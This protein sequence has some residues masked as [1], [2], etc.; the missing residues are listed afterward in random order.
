[1]MR[2]ETDEE[3]IAAVLH[4]VVE[5]THWTLDMLKN[6]GFS[7]AVLK[8]IEHLT[9]R[10]GEDYEKFIARVK[11]NQLAIKVKIA[12]LEDNM[13]LTRMSTI[14]KGDI[15]RLLKYHSAWL[16]LNGLE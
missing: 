10:E 15:K 6:E 14:S 16:K 8:A 11:R 2:M 3:R 12:D 7:T 1:M 9:K 5:D 4:D 13:D